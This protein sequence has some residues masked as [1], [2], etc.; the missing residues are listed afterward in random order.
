MRCTELCVTQTPR[1][2]S[3]TVARVTAR[4][5]FAAFFQPPLLRAWLTACLLTAVLRFIYN[6]YTARRLT[7]RP[8]RFDFF[9]SGRGFFIFSRFYRKAYIR[10]VQAAEER[11]ISFFDYLYE[12]GA[13]RRYRIQYRRIWTN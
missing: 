6:L 11:R 12:Y 9:P 10:T 2:T 8:R 3:L 4:T 13:H 1:V 5:R 7:T